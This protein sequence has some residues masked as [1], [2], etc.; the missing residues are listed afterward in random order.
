MQKLAGADHCKQSVNV[1]KDGKED[2]SL[3]GGSRLNNMSHV[4]SEHSV[5]MLT[6]SSESQLSLP[7]PL[8]ESMG[9]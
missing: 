6:A 9:E 5:T 1:V 2:L 8:G 3:G 7:C 4:L